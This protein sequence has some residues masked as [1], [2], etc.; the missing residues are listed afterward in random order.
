MLSDLIIIILSIICITNKL[1]SIQNDVMKKQTS[2]PKLQPSKSC[3]VQRINY[4]FQKLHT[5]LIFFKND[6]IIFNFYYILKQT[7]L[8]KSVRIHFLL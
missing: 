8:Y 4:M 1:M 7:N 3:V 6:H 5:L 2:Y